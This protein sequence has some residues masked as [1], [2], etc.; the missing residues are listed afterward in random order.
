MWGKNTTRLLI[1]S[2]CGFPRVAA[3]QTR[4][5]N[6]RGA[7]QA[8]CK[9]SVVLWI[10]ISAA[11][12][13]CSTKTAFEIYSHIVE[14]NPTQRYLVYYGNHVLCTHLFY[15][16]NHLHLLYSPFYAQNNALFNSRLRILAFIAQQWTSKY[17][18]ICKSL[19]E[20]II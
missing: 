12:V 7:Q 15:S 4:V 6:M 17:A 8:C 14:K 20:V 5:G 2:S 16:F 11:T 1:F 18:H 10:V 13:Y 19:S 3:G 9:L